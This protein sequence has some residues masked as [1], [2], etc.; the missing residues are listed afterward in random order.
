MPIGFAEFAILALVVLVLFGGGKIS[1]LMG[2][3]GRGLTSFKRGLAESK[4]EGF[5]GAGKPGAASKPAEA[6]V[7]PDNRTA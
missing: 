7:R 3:L 2:D 6:P 4:D 5:L 1:G